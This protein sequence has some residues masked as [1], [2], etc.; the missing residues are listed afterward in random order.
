MPECSSRASV[1]GRDSAVKCDANF[2]LPASFAFYKETLLMVSSLLLFGIDGAK[3]WASSALSYE[4]LD[5]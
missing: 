1:V 5:Y 2:L 3:Y 4:A